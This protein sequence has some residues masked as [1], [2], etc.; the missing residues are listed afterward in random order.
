MPFLQ[1]GTVDALWGG[2]S[3]AEG[4]SYVLWAVEQ[5][6]RSLPP[7]VEGTVAP[8]REPRSHPVLLSEMTDVDRCHISVWKGTWTTGANPTG[9]DESNQLL[10]THS[11]D[12][13]H[14]RAGLE[15]VTVTAGAG[16]KTR[17]EPVAA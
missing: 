3:P 7:G 15:R 16:G 5:H 1:R 10:Q 2:H 13:K 14:R 4:L 11:F 9:P 17:P 8:G 12:A 6:P